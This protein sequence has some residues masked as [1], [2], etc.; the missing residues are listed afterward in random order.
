MIRQAQFR[1]LQTTN[2]VI[3]AILAIAILTFA[4]LIALLPR[5][6]SGS[7]SSTTGSNVTYEMGIFTSDFTPSTLDGPVTTFTQRGYN[8]PFVPPGASFMEVDGGN[9]ILTKQGYYSGAIELA[10]GSPA[11]ASVNCTFSLIP[12]S[13]ESGFIV[14][15]G[16]YGAPPIARI[17]L[18]TNSSFNGVLQTS[19][20]FSFFF[21][22]TVPFTFP[23][24]LQCSTEDV[25]LVAINVIINRYTGITHV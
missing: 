19:W 22:R 25:T 7:S 1:T 16:Y 12:P 5:T 18:Y 17:I 23:S 24:L 11:T 14:M 6:P 3:S 15:S 10:G 13:F 2:V 8:E 21:N 4:L 9:L 20:S